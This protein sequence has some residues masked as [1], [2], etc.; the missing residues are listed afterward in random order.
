LNRTPCERRGGASA[1]TCLSSAAASCQKGHR[2]KKKARNDRGHA[3]WYTNDL[4][5]SG[6][7]EELL[8]GQS[9]HVLL[10]RKSGYGSVDSGSIYSVR[11]AGQEG[12]LEWGYSKACAMAARYNYLIYCVLK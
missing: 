6:P 8:L 3:E 4:C 2:R 12:E 11:D 5:D 7:Q 1:A 9:A 10:H